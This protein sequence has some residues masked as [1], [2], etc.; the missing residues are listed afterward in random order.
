VVVA[1]PSWA[2]DAQGL[3]PVSLALLPHVRWGGVTGRFDATQ[4]WR[5]ELVV[6]KLDADP[7]PSLALAAVA[8]F[9]HP[10]AEVSMA[11]DPESGRLGVRYRQRSPLSPHVRPAFGRPLD[12]ELSSVVVDDGRSESS[13]IQRGDLVGRFL[14]AVPGEEALSAARIEYTRV[15][16]AG[17]EQLRLW[18]AERAVVIG[19]NRGGRDRWPHPDGRRIEGAFG[20]ATGIDAI[21][22]SASVRLPRPWHVMTMLFL[23]A[24]LGAIVAALLAAVGAGG[25]RRG[26]VVTATALAA[27]LAS[28]MAY[29]QM[30]Y[31]CNPLV[32]ILAM[33]ISAELSARVL[34][35]RGVRT[36]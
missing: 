24:A 17:A 2:L 33:V 12:I 25:G 3:P 21:L 22:R 7:M 1:V 6:Q 11:L 20:H 30:L 32:P 14:L 15:F 28:A 23:G 31:L 4:P 36:A 34:Q 10:E 18:F 9:D 29:R 8:S 16:D 35:L 19:N 13:G 26:A 5:L 27:L